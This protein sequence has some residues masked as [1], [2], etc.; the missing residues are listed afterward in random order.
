MKKRGKRKAKI[1]AML[2]AVSILFSG[3]SYCMPV[4]AAKGGYNT[5]VDEG[6]AVVVIWATGTMYVVDEDR[7]I[8]DEYAYDNP[9]SH[10]SGFFVGKEGEDPQYLLTNH[11]V[12]DDY[13]KSGKGA[14]WEG[15]VGT[16]DSS[17]GLYFYLA[18]KM[19]LRVYYSEDDY[20]TV[21]VVDYLDQ[22][23]DADCAILKLDKPTDQ[24]KPLTIK[25]PTEDMRG[26]TVYA[27]GYPG[28]SENVFTG[29]SKWSMADATVTTGTI[30]KF[31]KS[32]ENNGVRT[33]QMDVGNSGGPLVTAGDGYVIGMNTWSVSRDGASVYYAI[34][35]EHAKALMDRN[36]VPYTM[37]EDK[38]GLPVT[39]VAVGCAVVI[40]AVAAGV[41]VLMKKKGQKPATAN[42]PAKAN[43]P[44]GNAQKA[45]GPVAH[46]L[47]PQ[48][49]GLIVSVSQT[50]IMVGRDRASC[51]IVY[52]EGTAGVSGR[53]CTIAFD[54]SVQSFMVTDIGS[55]Y[56]TFLMNGQ[57]LQ[58]NVPC[59][60]KVGDSFYVGDRA[61]VI[62]LELG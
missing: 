20:D 57:R 24:R 44:A 7:T 33:I 1:L 22:D 41:V 35:I 26:T 51:A 23:T 19:S 60:L 18:G 31:A 38:K 34:N 49:N 58:P 2:M 16:Y 56:G 30:S 12:V 8:Y 13:L 55:S 45:R 43:A 25:V 53:H 48:H 61:N 37:A 50:P 39:A 47:A 28:I 46:S 32:T 59:R 3:L 40:L 9:I 15:V 11:H 52:A 6:V 42:A 36:N 54:L 14:Q 62:R 4:Q 29:G 21:S 10:G 5:E 27:V 17:M